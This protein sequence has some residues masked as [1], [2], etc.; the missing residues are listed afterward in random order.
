M[1][2]KPQLSWYN[3]SFWNSCLSTKYALLQMIPAADVGKDDGK[4]TGTTAICAIQARDA[5]NAG[6]TECK[7]R[8]A[9]HQTMQFKKGVLVMQARPSA[10]EDWHLNNLCNTSKGCCQC[11]QG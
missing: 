6:K 1:L 4:Q 8:Q 7:A 5:V 10:K 9:L 2:V 11:R 3:S